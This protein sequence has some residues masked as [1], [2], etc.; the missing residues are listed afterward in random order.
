V[1]ARTSG[2]P[3]ASARVGRA[4]A[5]V[6]PALAM[7]RRGALR[8]AGDPAPERRRADRAAAAGRRKP[9]PSG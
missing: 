2:G 4:P 6:I 5:R 9:K 8:A 7:V 1:A 3:R